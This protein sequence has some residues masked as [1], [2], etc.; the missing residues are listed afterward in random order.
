MTD[1]ELAKRNAIWKNTGYKWEL[2]EGSEVGEDGRKFYNIVP[3]DAKEVELDNDKNEI[4][5]T[6]EKP[7]YSRP[8][9]FGWAP[10][11]AGVD[12][13]EKYQANKDI[14]EAAYQDA[15][16]KESYV[17]ADKKVTD[18]FVSRWLT[19]KNTG[20]LNAQSAFLANNTA[21]IDKANA[22]QL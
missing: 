9:G 12:L 8:T 19:K 21:D 5:L 6:Y 10:I 7:E 4:Q 1:E 13:L 20:E 15:P 3:T 16:P 22:V 14:L 11:K 2:M 18:N 17:G